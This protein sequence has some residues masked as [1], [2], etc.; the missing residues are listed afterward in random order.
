VDFA[1]VTIGHQIPRPAIVLHVVE[2]SPNVHERLEHGMRGDILDTLAADE[3]P[4][5]VTNGIAILLSRPDHV[6]S[7]LKIQQVGYSPK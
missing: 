5:T 1:P 7:C 2:S 6:S 3:D 4:P